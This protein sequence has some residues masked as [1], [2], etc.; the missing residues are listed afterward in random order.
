MYMCVHTY[1]L[2]SRRNKKRN[3]DYVGSLAPWTTLPTNYGPINYEFARQPIGVC[4]AAWGRTLVIVNTFVVQKQHSNSLGISSIFSNFL[5][6]F[7]SSSYKGHTH[8]FLFYFSWVNT[9]LGSR[10]IETFPGFFHSAFSILI[11]TSQSAFSSFLPQ[12]LPSFP[13]PSPPFPPLSLSFSLSLPPSLPSSFSMIA[14]WNGSTASRASRNIK[15]NV[16]D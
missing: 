16:S 9:V 14:D 3:G 8:N 2:P 4:S 1:I 13:S 7:F 5:L 12:H 10:A 11:S 15:L 6:S